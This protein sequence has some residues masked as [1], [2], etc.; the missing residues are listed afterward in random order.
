MATQRFVEVDASILT[1]LAE[2]VMTT[3]ALAREVGETSRYIYSRCKR[4]EQR[5]VIPSKLSY[6]RT[7]YCVDDEKVVT[8]LEYDTCHAAGHELRTTTYAERS[9]RLA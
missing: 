8:R 5:N 7:L 1:A 4:L 6:G 3:A 2:G 9:W